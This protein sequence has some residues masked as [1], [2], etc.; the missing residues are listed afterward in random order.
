MEGEGEN[1]RRPS[2]RGRTEGA[3]SEGENESGGL[4]GG[5]EAEGAETEGENERG[6]SLRGRGRGGGV[7]G[8]VRGVIGWPRTGKI[9]GCLELLTYT[10]RPRADF[11][12]AFL[13]LF[14]EHQ[15]H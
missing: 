13:E 15:N 12:L 6:L 9:L 4:V 1:E 7:E 3:K 5:V 10:E 2:R 8:V 14:E 11:V